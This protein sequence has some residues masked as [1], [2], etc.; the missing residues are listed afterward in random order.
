MP[1]AVSSGVD[2]TFYQEEIEKFMEVNNIKLMIA[3]LMEELQMAFAL[4]SKIK[5]NELN[6]GGDFT[7][8]IENAAND[9]AAFF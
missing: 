8:Y 6:G 7:N 3:Q 5:I 4:V 1:I 2:V 9:A